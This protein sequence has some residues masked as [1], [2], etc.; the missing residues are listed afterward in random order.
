MIFSRRFIIFFTCVL[1]V[2]FSCTLTVQAADNTFTPRTPEP[3]V[4]IPGLNFTKI[5][6]TPNE[7]GENTLI[8]VP[9]LGEYI[10]AV[11]KYAVAVASIIAVVMIVVAGFQ[12]TASGGSP[13]AIN[14][15]KKRI[16]NAVTGLILALG[17]YTIL[18]TVNPDLVTFKSLKIEYVK[19]CD[20]D[21]CTPETS[22]VDDKATDV[23]EN[24]PTNLPA[25]PLSTNVIFKRNGSSS[26]NGTQALVSAFSDAI[27]DFQKTHSQDTL[28]ITSAY[29]SAQNQYAIMQKQCGCPAET[30]LSSTDMNPDQILAQCTNKSC[31][32]VG[33]VVSRKD[34]QLMVPLVS[35]MS[36]NAIDVAVNGISHISCASQS[37]EIKQSQGTLKID[38]GANDCVPK[39]QQ[40]LIRVMLNHNFCVGMQD[41]ASTRESW[42][43]EVKTG[44]K[45]IFCVDDN[46][47]NVK[48]LYY[49]VH[50]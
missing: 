47:N 16:V 36:G 11:Y 22:D 40:E 37:E 33:K 9:F 30:S 8:S 14:E 28:V 46:D 21:T 32:N 17:S 44:R 18:Y 49:V 38:K 29:R 50:P 26:P 48:K 7:N 1:I 25:L 45:S 6:P 10:A 4:N 34:G 43:F 39:K 15:A 24:A 31:T 3:A 35:H 19:P 20:I 13:D 42:H 5:T 12:W 2:F 41:N 27:K 23:P